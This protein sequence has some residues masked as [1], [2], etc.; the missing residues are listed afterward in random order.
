MTTESPWPITAGLR[1]RR[2]FCPGCGARRMAETAARLVDHVIPR[3]PVRQWVLAFPIPLRLL[4][5]AHPHLL[6]SVLQIVHRVLSTFLI[7]QTGLERTEAKT[8]AV[9]FVPSVTLIPA[10]AGIS[11][12]ANLNIHLHCLVLDG[13]YRTTEGLP[14]FH[15]VRAPTAE[16]LQTLLARIIKRLMNRMHRDVQL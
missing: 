8:G 14:V 7:Q 16:E 13:V 15:A 5:A 3:V 4:F 6:S 2:G 9:R 12:S 10:L 11:G 1:K